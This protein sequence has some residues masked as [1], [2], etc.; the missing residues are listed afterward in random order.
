MIRSSPDPINGRNDDSAPS[1][2]AI[3]QAEARPVPLPLQAGN[4]PEALKALPQW[5]AWRY[6]RRD[7]EWTKPPISPHTGWRASST[8]PATWGTFNQA[9]AFYHEHHGKGIDG[10]GFVFSAADP[11]AGVDLDDC[12]DPSTGILAEWAQAEIAALNSYAEVSPSGTGVKLFLEGRLPP[13]RHRH[14]HYELY[15]RERYFTLTGQ[16]LPD[17]P[18]TVEARQAE[19]T[20]LHTRL[21]PPKQLATA[22][23]PFRPDD[24]RGPG[25]SLSDDQLI[26]RA[27]QAKNGDRFARLWA[28][29]TSGY[30]SPSEADLALCND[31]AFWTGGDPVQLDHLFRQSGLM[32]PKWEERHYA[33][34]R[35]YAQGTIAK[36]LEGRTEFYTGETMQT[37]TTSTP[38][39]NGQSGQQP[40]AWPAPMADEAFHGLAGEIVRCLVPH[41]EADPVAL[42]GQL[43]VAFGSAIGRTAHFLVENTQHFGNEFLL[44]IGPTASGGKGTSWGRI[45][46]LMSHADPEWV[47]QR[48]RTGLCSGEG[49]VWHIRD[50]IPAFGHLKNSK[51]KKTAT[52]AGDDPGIRDK[53]L[54][55]IEEEFAQVL[56]NAARKGS[57]LGTQLRQAWDGHAMETMAKA[58]NFARV[59]APHVSLISHCTEVDL[60]LHLARTDCRNG[61]ANRFLITCV[62]RS[63]ELP[64][65]GDPNPPGLEDLRGRLRQALAFGGTAG[66]RKRDAEANQLWEQHYHHLNTPPPGLAGDLLARA[67][68]HVMRL[69]NLYSL[70]DQSPQIRAPHLQAA[71]T[72]WDYCTHSVRHVFGDLLGNPVADT[73]EDALRYAASEGLTRERINNLFN[74]NKSAGVLSRALQLLCSLGRAHYRKVSK[75]STPGA[76]PEVWYF[77]PDP[78]ATTKETKQTK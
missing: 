43:L 37:R 57:I 33:D 30:P 53:R 78:E 67:K 15:D 59:A 11:F 72:F 4:I 40:H 34:G 9:L 70:L 75:G 51:G 1:K 2:A 20:A 10:I 7:G 19:L 73:I 41:S 23:P 27:M 18:A 76:R 36:A 74:R 32:R 3:D 68:P 49:L 13:G 16:H 28:G 54:L 56:I 12:R 52:H 25:S 66:E 48:A 61:F 17:T 8:K 63:K 22:G 55:A 77:G 24:T 31:L 6:E 29:D 38:S 14:G 44:L 62:K 5:V 46:Y 35:T 26:H 21:S 50:P 65:G 42:L 71:L 60:T 47:E 45:R 64:H 39:L 58:A 69:A